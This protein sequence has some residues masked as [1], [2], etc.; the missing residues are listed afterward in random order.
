LAWPK[1]DSDDE[2]TKDGQ[3]KSNEQ[4]ENAAIDGIERL[5]F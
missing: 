5:V 2:N 3:D 1:Q 4:S